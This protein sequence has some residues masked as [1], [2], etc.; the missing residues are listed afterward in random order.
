[1][2]K[3]LLI[4]VLILFI[5]AYFEF[6]SQPSP[7][8]KFG[9]TFSPSYATYLGLDW[10]RSYDLI[11]NDLKV[12]RLRLPTYWREVEPEDNKFNFADTDYLLNQAEKANAEVLLVI[13]M[14]QPRWPE[15]QIPDWARKLTVNQ[16]QVQVFNL[17]ETVV[18]R[19]KDHPNIW[20]WQ[21]ENEPLFAFGENCDAPDSQ[22]LQQ[23]TELVKKLDPQRPIVITDTGEWRFWIT[24]MQ[25]SNILGI[26][27][28]RYANI[29]GYG[30]LYYPFPKLFYKAKSEIVR[31]FFAPNNQKTIIT[32]LQTEAWST[33]SLKD[34]KIDEQIRL[35]SIKQFKDNITFAKNTGFDEIY[36]W[37]VE[38]W[39]YLAKYNHPEY[40]EYAKT[41][42][43]VR[44]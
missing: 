10:Q 9:V 13:G 35:L 40:L 25:L 26:S 39:I 29:E 2:K 5:T 38:W 6:A 23:E 1:M 16:R 44:N 18:T 31:R 4:S 12:K 15:C 33:K 41:L 21:V 37:G 8:V 30:F 42:F 3:L 7:K 14:K 22:F 11:L 20:A 36:F 32:E 34:T 43:I 28:Y 24:S 19:Y 17:I 27:V